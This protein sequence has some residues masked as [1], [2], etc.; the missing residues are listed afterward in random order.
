LKQVF[1]LNSINIITYNAY[2]Q[3]HGLNLKHRQTLG[4]KMTWWSKGKAHEK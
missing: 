1:Q 3:L 4:W 2:S